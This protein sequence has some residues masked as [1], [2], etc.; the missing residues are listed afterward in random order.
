M[1]IVRAAALAGLVL[2][3][4]GAAK[5]ETVVALPGA[6]CKEVRQTLELY[7]PIAPGFRQIEMP[8]PET[9]KR[10]RARCAALSPSA[11][12]CMSKTSRSAR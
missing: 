9:R 4:T 7:V 8:F 2:H 3:A 6:E 12:A 10:S 5:A 11:P 1:S